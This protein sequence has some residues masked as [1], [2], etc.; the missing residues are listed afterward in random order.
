MTRAPFRVVA[1]FVIT[2]LVVSSAAIRAISHPL[3]ISLQNTDAEITRPTRQFLSCDIGG[4]GT[5]HHY[6]ESRLGPGV[7]GNLPGK[8]RL[9]LDSHSDQPPLAFLM[10]DQ[11]H[12]S[13]VNQ[14][15]QIRLNLSAGSCGAPTLQFDGT[16]TSGSGTWTI[17]PEG[18]LDAYRQATG[19]GTFSFDARLGSGNSNPWSFDLTGDIHVLQPS[20]KV[21]FIRSFWGR[22]GAD[23]AARIVTVFFLVTNTGPGDSFRARLEQVTAP[24]GITPIEFFPREL[25]D[26]ASGEW[27]F[28]TVR[29]RVGLKGQKRGPLLVNRQFETN[30][31]LVL[32]DALD[33]PTSHDVTVNVTAPAFPPPL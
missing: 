15:G 24:E 29:Y 2:G 13:L 10:Q 12:L 18:A 26:L 30:L 23:Y 22:L 21:E 32:P 20:V 27:I 9:N 7:F 16:T 25:D 11:S 3:N 1:L 14:R 4:S 33:E 19:S 5:H 31:R 6:S 8:A 17:D 28:L